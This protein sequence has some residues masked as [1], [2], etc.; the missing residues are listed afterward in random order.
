LHCKRFVK[1]K[2]LHASQSIVTETPEHTVFS[3]SLM[4]NYELESLILSFGERA[5]VLAPE[6][7]K[8]RIGERLELAVG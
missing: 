7:L 4:L 2:P 5:R 1:T 8:K 6:V 3:Y